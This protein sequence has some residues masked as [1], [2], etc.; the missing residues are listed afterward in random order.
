[1][2]TAKRIHQ[3]LS[4][5]LAL[6]ALCAVANE[7][8]HWSVG[9]WDDT[10][11]PKGVLLTDNAGWWGRCVFTGVT[12]EYE[13]KPNNPYD[14]FMDNAKVF[15]RRL[16]DGNA[17]GGWQRP[18]GTTDKRPIVAVFDF[19]RPCVFN[20]V[21]LMS[22][23]SPKAAASISVSND[24]TNWTV[25]A[26]VACSN[27]LTRVRPA[28]SGHGRYLRVSY[29]SKTSPSTWLDEV[30]AWGD[31]EVSAE[32][33]ENIQPI[34]RGD[35][36]RIPCATNGAIEWV[37]L[38]DPTTKSKEQFGQPMISFAPCASAGGEILMA[39]NETETRYFA[40]A[41]GSTGTVSVPLSAPDFGEGVKTEL[42]IG[43]LVRGQRS[44]FKLTDKQR[45]DMMLTGEEPEKAFD[46]KRLG[47]IPFFSP[48]M[49]PPAN[50]ARKYLG[51]PEQVVG[52]P[53]RVE[54]APGECA[55]VMMR[56]TTD[57]AAPGERKGFLTAG[58]AT[59]PV[60]LRVVDATLPGDDGSPWVFT[61]GPFTPQFPFESRTRYENDA[62]AVRELGVTMIEGFPVNGSK[63]DLATRGRRDKCFF[64][65]SG[66]T[67][68]LDAMIYNH[69][70]STLDDAARA[71]ISNHLAKVRARA[72][73]AGVRPEQ[74]VLAV[75]DE[76]GKGNAKVCGEACRYIREIAP[77]MN[78]Y[79]NPCFWNET[80]FYPTD[81]I[82]ESL[83]D[84]YADV[85]DVSVPY[86]SLT[87][88]AKGR[89]LLWATKRRVNA[90][91][92]HP[93]HRAGRSISWANFRYGLD[94]FAYWCYYWNTGGNTWDI[95]TWTIYSFETKMALPLENGVAITPV[96]EEMR[97]AWEDWRL[98]S[99]L[100]ASGKT[101][102]LDS[103]LKNFGDSFDPPNMETSKPYKCDFQKLRDKALRAFDVI[104]CDAV[105]AGRSPAIAE[106]H[107]L[108][109]P[110][111]GSRE[112][113]RIDPSAAKKCEL[114][115]CVPISD[116]QQMWTPDMQTPFLERKWWISKASAP[117]SSMPCI[118]WFNM[119]ESNVFFFGAA[120][121]EWDCLVES[122]INQERGVYE[123]KLTVAA[124]SGVLK[125]FDVTL[126]RRAVP[127]T[128]SVDEWRDSLPYA[129]GTYPAAA[130]EPA[131]CSW[132]AVH[133]ALDAQWV[134]RTAAIAVDL[135]FGT[136]ILDD[137]WS[138]DEAKRVS[139]ETIKTWY[140]DVGAWDSFSPVKFPDFRRHRERM[141]KLGLN[142][143]VWVAPYFLGSRSAAFRRWGYDR[144]PNVNVVEGNAL[145]D[146]E[147][148]AMMESVA[149]QLVR[150]MRDSEL[151]GLK[152]DFLD[153]VKPS[154]ADP[155]GARSIEYIA[156]LM[157]RLREVK[158]DGV[159]EF[160]QDYATPITASLATQFRA[161]D[162]PFEWQANL[163]RIAQI[164]LTM[165]D[166]IPIHS[167]PI[168]WADSETDDNV[169]RHFMA[170]MAGVPMLSM[171]MEKMSPERRAAVRRW[172]RLYRETVA[173]FQR[174]G[175]WSVFYRN[176]GLVGL[177]GKLSGKSLVIVNDPAGFAVLRAA[178]GNGGM[179][180]FNLGF[181]SLVLPNGETVAPARAYPE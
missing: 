46:A 104:V 15:G 89:R 111:A 142:Y 17:Q 88:S 140:R 131:F 133:A 23:K 178:A 68:Q 132:Y 95:R 166:G 12:Y 60:A 41:N 78:T 162:V 180:V 116:V 105:P 29:L 159:F 82:V 103:L 66:L 118:A 16:L 173:P 34:P 160:R 119:A 110:K 100:K 31:G 2:K 9:G 109:I 181:E 11:A 90:S 179:I 72:E 83:G 154:V 62:R 153:A 53:T 52:F 85:V 122:K 50:F 114:S 146:I 161:G 137:G 98:L 38:Q 5:L 112:V 134:E 48:D 19:K 108:S 4:I 43:G 6:A 144:R 175:K 174:D 64:Y 20:E 74:V 67:P 32:Y 75:I 106:A 145:T 151:D 1:M 158:P 147:N 55:V 40:V 51:N 76:P 157:K 127:W 37:Q 70:I 172:M 177:V 79:L 63:V 148:Q 73:A 115:F 33:P 8:I 21:D 47:I 164:R 120:A 14:C 77:D 165:G 176:G 86:R 117:Q 135:G 13:T 59:R 167:D 58:A 42:L 125:P 169:S 57:G 35:L 39:R 130:W 71:E 28:E 97:E 123:V 124:G 45:F 170:A 99:L 143:V 10:G 101:E 138:Y 128:Q 136:F 139:P 3:S 94:G 113:V 81:V 141:R 149:D 107:E 49:V 92:A 61:W 129:R 102:L 171:D 168:Y 30:L 163:L 27:A 44:K 155:H 56:V 54:I 69:R 24:G 87:E 22:E 150:L 121:L 36:L 65:T 91:Y 25:F 156:D 26:E 18:V 93:A 7:P 126:D 96:Y 80:Q 152:I 84:F